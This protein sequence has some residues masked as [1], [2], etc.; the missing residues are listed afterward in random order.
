MKPRKR[1]S[2]FALL[3]LLLSL[4]VLELLLHGLARVV[5]RVDALLSS[6]WHTIPH[7][8]KDDRLGKRPNPAYPEHDRKGFRNAR[9]PSQVDIVA[10]GDSQT[11][12]AGVKPQEAWPRQL[13]SLSG[14]SVYSI[15]YGGYGPTHS[16][17]LWEEA[18]A[19]RP[20]VII[21]ALYSGN[22]LYDSFNHVYNQ[23]QLPRLKSSDPRIRNAVKASED[24]EPIV[25]SV[26]RIWTM[27]KANTPKRQPLSPMRFLSRHSKLYA[28]LRRARYELTHTKVTKVTALSWEQAKRFANRNQAYCQIFDNGQF[29]T[30][31]T[32][33]F[34]LAVHNLR[35]PRIEEGLRI[36]LDAISKMHH[37]AAK[38]GIEFFVVL[39]PTK[40]FVFHALVQRSSSPMP[41]SYQNLVTNENLLWNRTKAFLQEHGIDYVD[42]LQALRNSLS[43]GNQP[44]K[45]SH[46]GH[47]NALGH[48]AI[49]TLVQSH[50]KP[51]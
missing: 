28:L 46:D 34:R 39:I 44:Y 9:V 1:R 29:K 15:A 11:Y 40:E 5:P 2:L 25:R 7:T 37:L 35:D 51:R 20:K 45:I 13:E 49:A 10:L 26:S 6:P 14:A 36:S 19:L 48:R 22:D 42:S 31:F 24:S 38:E 16:L 30:V 27:G 32:S 4:L 50:M 3:T 43:K 18:V 17:I 21:E 8:I 47:P 33:E 23:Q 12:G 41:Q